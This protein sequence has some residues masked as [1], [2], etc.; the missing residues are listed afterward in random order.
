[1]SGHESFIG[2]MPIGSMLVKSQ[3]H[4]VLSPHISPNLSLLIS[5]DND[6]A[7]GQNPWY[8][9]LGVFG[10]PPILESILVV[11]LGCSLGVRFGF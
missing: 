3:K 7:V 5:M 10:A 4:V 8:P 6:V 9:I 11:G 1:M 2:K